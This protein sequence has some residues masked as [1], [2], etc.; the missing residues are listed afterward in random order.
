MTDEP[1]GARPQDAGGRPHRRIV[2]LKA[3]P[4][5][6]AERVELATGASSHRDAFA[7]AVRSAGWLWDADAAALRLGAE[8]AA[9]L[10]GPRSPGI[11]V[12]GEPIPAPSIPV[13]DRLRLI[14][15]YAAALDRLM[16][17]ASSR[18]RSGVAL[19]APEPDVEPAPARARRA[20]RRA[21]DYG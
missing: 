17:S 18:S 19:T 10:D 16:L 6:P 20:R 7:L 9:L 14:D 5:T 8:L 2:R 11:G 3:R 13:A 12:T 21:V 15:A 4:L 1:A